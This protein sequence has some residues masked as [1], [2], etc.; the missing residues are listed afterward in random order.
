MFSPVPPHLKDVRWDR[1]T[2]DNLT[3]AVLLFDRQNHLLA[4]NPAAEALL[5]I[6]T[7]KARGMEA[8]VL[9]SGI[10][11]CD[12]ASGHISRRQSFTKRET[13][14][15]L[16]GKEPVQLDCIVSPLNHPTQSGGVLVELIPL[17]HRQRITRA[18]QL[19]NQSET[20]R[21]S[22]RRFAHEVRNPLG[23][24]RGAAQLL[25]RELHEDTLREYTTIIIQEADRLSTLI[26]RMLGPRTPPKKRQLNIHEVMERV[27]ILVQAEAP[28]GVSLERDYDPSIPELYGDPD[29]LIQAV[30]NVARNAIQSLG[31]HGRV[32]FSTRV[33]RQFTIGHR[34]HRLVVRVDITDDGPGIPEGLEETIF[35]PMVTGLGENGTGLGLPIAQSLVN[36]HG[37]LIECHGQPGA[38]TFSILLPVAFDHGFSPSRGDPS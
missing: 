31:D 6:S 3:T 26:D 22:M 27:R 36:Q 24:L 34:R 17:V 19:L 25:A 29:L 33:H 35:Y 18:K 5:D 20:A 10:D 21:M 28:P 13:Q 38:T 11:G 1:Q 16:P 15:R 23:G 30:L 9:F 2:I 12:D 32:L 8:N 37:G 14:L 4:M 7:N